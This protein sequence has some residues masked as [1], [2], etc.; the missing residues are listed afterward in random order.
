MAKSKTKIKPAK[1]S[2]KKV[3]ET[4]GC[5]RPDIANISI[6]EDEN[7]IEIAVLPCLSIKDHIA[8]VNDTIDMCFIE[9]DD[10]T[11]VYSPEFEKFAL[12]YNAVA[13]FTNIEL[14]SDTEEVW[15]FL[16]YTNIGDEIWNR[17]P[18]YIFHEIRDAVRKGIEY[19]KERSV[20][21]TKFDQIIDR[22]GGLFDAIK[23]KTENTSL[24][25]IVQ[26]LSSVMPEFK[27]DIQKLL[28]TGAAESVAA[29]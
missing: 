9:G 5:W 20:K 27:D 25:E 13:Y 3:F 14:S 1:I 17:V 12:D 23:T 15:K 7:A 6:G 24:D 28:K 18:A 16:H 8:F 10:G 22:L 11:E 29:E 4:I 21:S 2:S 19:R 26:T